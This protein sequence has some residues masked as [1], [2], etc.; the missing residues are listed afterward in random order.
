MKSD[1]FGATDFFIDCGKCHKKAPHIKICEARTEYSNHLTRY[2][3]LSN[4]QITCF[5][6]KHGQ[7]DPVRTVQID[8][9][10]TA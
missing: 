2:C 4:R 1:K 10:K 8:P 7:T 9:F 3:E 5:I 6:G